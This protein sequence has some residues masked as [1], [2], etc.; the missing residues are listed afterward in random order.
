VVQRQE[1]PLTIEKDGTVRVSDFVVPFS[2]L[3]SP[4]AKAA[5]IHAQLPPP[6]HRTGGA[7]DDIGKYRQFANDY[8]SIPWLAKAKE[9]YPCDVETVTLG[10]V[11]ADIVTP[12]SG[13]A[14]E[15]QDR[16]LL[17]FHGGG[18]NSGAKERAL[19][20]AL[21]IASVGRI[22]VATLD[23]RLAPEH[24]FP[25]ASEDIGNAY[26]ALLNNYRPENIGLFGCSAGGTLSAEAVSWLAQEGLPRPGAIAVVCANAVRS[27]KGDTWYIGE[28]LGFGGGPGPRVRNYFD[29]ADTHDPLVSPGES[30]EALAK[31]PPTIFITGSRDRFLSHSAYMQIQLAKAGVEAELFVWDGMWHGFTWV[32]DLPESRE[33]F[34]ITTKFFARKLGR[35]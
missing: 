29:G 23:Y 13:I 25:A 7:G 30:P 11:S 2:D 20:E 14:P 18:F 26:R 4:E 15:N 24:V 6:P 3:A 35:R 9:L 5:Y 28:E 27:Y 21:P 16:I 33:A 34:D 10:G 19:V 8:E 12:A 17:N 32:T 22:K 31:F 1:E